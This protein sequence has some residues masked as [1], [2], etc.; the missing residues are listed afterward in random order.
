MKVIITTHPFGIPNHSPINALLEQFK[1]ECIGFNKVKQKYS[2]E[3]HIEILKKEQPDI[4]I[5]GTEK[6]NKDVLDLVPNLKMISRV[7]IGLDSVDLKEC[8][9]RGIVVTYTPDAP[10][11]AVAELTIGQMYNCLRNI[12]YSNK[13]WHRYIGKELRDC[14][15]GIFGVGR[16]GKLVIEKLQ[17]LKPRRIFINDINRKL[18]KNIQRCEYASKPQLLSNSDII[19]IHIPLIEPGINPTYNN[20]DFITSHDLSI[21]KHDAIIINTSRGGVINE[22]DLY[23]WL[24][25]CP[26]AKSAI[27]VYETEPY[28][29]PLLDL[30]NAFLTPHLGSCSEKSRFDMEMGAVE[31]VLNFVNNKKMFNQVV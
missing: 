24:I 17:N 14:N 23:K 7:G 12:Q 19:T 22:N 29:G 9:N 18:C 16:V 4:I 11:N 8:K 30:Q 1:Y 26:N 2:K 21:M 6:Y 13:T 20:H 25:K 28:K 31:E 27:D 10:S 5:A 3:Q 15:I